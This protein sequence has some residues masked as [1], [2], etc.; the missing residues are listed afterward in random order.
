MDAP[1]FTQ[2]M[3]ANGA[4]LLSKEDIDNMADHFIG[5]LYDEDAGAW[6]YGQYTGCDE[7][8]LYA[9]DIVHDISLI[10]DLDSVLGSREGD[11]G[12]VLVA[13]KRGIIGIDSAISRIDEI[14]TEAPD[15][16]DHLRTALESLPCTSEL[17]P[18]LEGGAR[19]EMLCDRCY[20]I[21][22]LDELCEEQEQQLED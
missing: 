8:G 13:F 21:T 16:W 19:V 12:A 3:I 11:T 2:D 9:I 1:E 18:G 15:S 6:V 10:S 20:A 14:Y 17:C 4:R 5:W 22:K 7:D